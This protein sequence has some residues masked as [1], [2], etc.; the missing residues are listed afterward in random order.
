VTIV[1]NECAIAVFEGAL[2]SEKEDR[3]HDLKEG[4]D[5]AGAKRFGRSRY[6]VH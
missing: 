6:V 3:N 2:G 4:D 5:E 1:L